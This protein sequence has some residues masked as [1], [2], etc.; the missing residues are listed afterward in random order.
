MFPPPGCTIN[1]L[2]F[3]HAGTNFNFYE[4]RILFLSLQQK[5]SFVMRVRWNGHIKSIP[6]SPSASLVRVYRQ[7]AP[8]N[9]EI[10][11]KQTKHQTSKQ[12][13]YTTQR[14]NTRNTQHNTKQKEGNKKQKIRNKQ[15]N[16]NKNKNKTRQNKHNK[17][18]QNKTKQ[19]KTKQNKNNK[20]TATATA[21][22]KYTNS[23]T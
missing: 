12:P 6:L 23:N 22:A 1:L 16:K 8:R 2:Q 11:N 18:K 7:K 17:I 4:L 3:C 19:N 20:S 21:T 14:N 9:R 13:E 10:M 5:M 15:T